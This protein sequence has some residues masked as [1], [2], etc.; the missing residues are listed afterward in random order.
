MSKMTRMFKEV[1]KTWNPVVGCLHGCVYCWARR[2]AKRQKRRCLYCYRF[3]PHFHPERLQRV[4]KSGLVFVCDMGDLYGDWIHPEVIR[5]VIEVEI[6]YPDV[7]FLSL[8]KNPRRYHK[9]DSPDN[10]IL[11]ATIE[12]TEGTGRISRA[13][14]PAVRAGAMM[15]LRRDRKFGTIEP[16]LN[17]DL[18]RFVR[19]IKDV[20]PK[21]VYVG[22][23]NYGHRLPE[24]S[25]AKT[26]A[27][28]AELSEFTEVRCKTI[29][30]AW[31]EN[32][33]KRAG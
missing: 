18:P 17:F 25:L 13:P 7:T 26:K 23:D 3:V 11:G 1:T 10:A 16:I 31:W 4:P 30:P 15:T 2:Q 5:Q 29:R 33:G 14:M 20:D 8:T 12:T 28:I 19:W 22:Y 6:D 21:F 27:L 9:F 24:P 32:P